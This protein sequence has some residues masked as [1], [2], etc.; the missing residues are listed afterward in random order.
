MSAPQNRQQN[1]DQQQQT[2]HQGRP[3]E[4]YLDRWRRKR[5]IV[6]HPGGGKAAKFDH[7]AKHHPVT[8]MQ[9]VGGSIP[10]YV[11]NEF[12]YVTRNPSL[13]GVLCSY[14]SRKL[15]PETYTQDHVVP[16]AHGGSVLGREN[17]VPSCGPCN[18]EK[19]NNSLLHFL[20]LRR[21]NLFFVEEGIDAW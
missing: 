6:T 3:P 21:R 13:G 5:G 18:R 17:V 12:Y 4:W 9:I 8:P 2:L 1:Y 10:A 20:Y 19:S 7:I 14:C 16:R 15:S 11:T